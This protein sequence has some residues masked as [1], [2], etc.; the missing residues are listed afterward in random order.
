MIDRSTRDPEVQAL[1]VKAADG[2]IDERESRELDRLTA[3]DPSLRA[4]IEELRTASRAL[5]GFGLRDPNPDEWDRFEKT[6]LPRSER[7]L[8]WLLMLAGI[9]V[10][11]GLG[12]FGL[13]VDAEVPLAAKIGLGALIGGL[14]VLAIH[15]GRRTWRERKKDPYKDI[16][17]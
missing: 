17:R 9:A 4:E 6:L 7:M 10:L 1:I 3:E 5:A 11:A 14:A 16:V 12:L 13:V 15:V 8:G 2:E